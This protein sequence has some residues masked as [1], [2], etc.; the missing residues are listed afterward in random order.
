M[1]LGTYVEL[2][3]GQLPAHLMAPDQVASA[4]VS[5]SALPAS[6]ASIFGFECRLDA[7][8]RVDLQCAIER[9]S[10]G[11]RLLQEAELPAH[12]RS[13]PEWEWLSTLA[14][15]W[16]SRDTPDVRQLWLGFD[17]GPVA[18]PPRPLVH[19]RTDRLERADHVAALET[20]FGEPLDPALRHTINRCLDAAPSPPAY[21]GMMAARGTGALRWT[22]PLPIT[23]AGDFLAVVGWDGDR[24]RLRELLRTIAEWTS[25][26]GLS[27]NLTDRVEPYLGLELLNWTR[28]AAD[29]ATW[30]RVLATLTDRGLCTGEKGRALL[31][32]PGI[33]HEHGD[34][35]PESLRTS[36]E[37]RDVAVRQFTRTLSHIK[38]VL[39]PGAPLRAKAYLM[40]RHGWLSLEPLR[41][42]T[43]VHA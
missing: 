30:R 39:S 26:V 37:Y 12:L 43:R 8:P 40:I 21:V 11:H 32:V 15:R 42:E 5:T 25:D 9:D 34:S 29:L 36:D 16:G 7:D 1:S 13:L 41:S 4:T 2:C 28:P 10:A 14:G 35:W 22:L 19:V 23:E 20:L 27:L 17:S 31:E 6:L 18:S 3:A 24:G 38:L 33:S